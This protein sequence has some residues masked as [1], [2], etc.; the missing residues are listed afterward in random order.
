MRFFVGLHQPHNAV[1]FLETCC[2][3]SVNRLR[4]RRGPFPVGDW[5]MDSG[6]F[7]ELSRKQAVGADGQ[8][9]PNDYRHPPEEYAS[10]IVR[11]KSNG[12]LLAAV[13]QD[14]MCEPFILEKTGLTIPIHQRQTIER[15]D[16]IVAADTGVYIM[17]VLQG[18]ASYEYV[19]H[20]RQYGSRL[21][22]FAWTGVGSICKRNSDPLAVWRV[23]AAI[24]EER[25]DL[26]L[27]GFGL[28]ITSLMYQP[29]RDLLYSSDSMAWSFHARMHNGSGNDWRDAK[30]FAEK[31]EGVCKI[32]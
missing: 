24:K 25:P 12:R 20:I 2:F 9:L 6:A 31:I 16:R 1:H 29:I 18:Y 22:P 19:G 5:I 23:L 27:H 17:P 32:A 3:I 14:K 7:S 4:R 11:W 28:K 30:D 26:R 13:S 15:Y 8:L 10:Q 21:A